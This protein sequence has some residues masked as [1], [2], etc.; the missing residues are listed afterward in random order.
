ML[1]ASVPDKPFNAPVSDPTITSR[2]QIKVDY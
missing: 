1:L 2:T